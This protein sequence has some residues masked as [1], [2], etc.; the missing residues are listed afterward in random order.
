MYC[1]LVSSTV[2]YSRDNSNKT[3]CMVYFSYNSLSDVLSQN[4]ALNYLLLP[5]KLR[6]P[7]FNKMSSSQRFAAPSC[8]GSLQYFRQVES[9]AR[10]IF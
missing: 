1:S 8:T 5:L 3:T 7:S 10:C 4:L 6:P 2:V 9:L